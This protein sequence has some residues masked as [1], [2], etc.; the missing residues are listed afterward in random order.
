LDKL[1]SH[2]YI[3]K[4]PIS[5]YGE[6]ENSSSYFLYKIMAKNKNERLTIES[7]SLIE[8][9]NRYLHPPTSFHSIEYDDAGNIIYDYVWAQIDKKKNLKFCSY[10]KA[11]ILKILNRENSQ[12]ISNNRE[13]LFDIRIQ[14][15]NELFKSLQIN[16]DKYLWDKCL[17]ILTRALT[18]DEM[19]FFLKIDN[20]YKKF[21]MNFGDRYARWFRPSNGG[22]TDLFEVIGHYEKELKIGTYAKTR[23]ALKQ[24]IASEDF[25]RGF[26][27]EDYS[28]YFKYVALGKK[29][30][31]DKALELFSSLQA[32][33][34]GLWKEYRYRVREALE[35]KFH[36]TIRIETTIPAEHANEL[37][38]HLGYFA[39][40]FK[41]HL[42]AFGQAPKAPPFHLTDTPTASENVFR[43]EGQNWRITFQGKTI[44][45]RNTKGLQCIAFLLRHPR[46]QF[47]VLNLVREVDGIP[48][49]SADKGHKKS[50]LAELRAKWKEKERQNEDLKKILAEKWK[51]ADSSLIS[52]EEDDPILDFQAM[53]EIN[54]K[55]NWL[56]EQIEEAMNENDIGKEDYLKAE[57]KAILEHLSQASNISGKSRQFIDEGEKARKRVA[58]AIRRA[59][60]AIEKENTD[61]W[62][63][64]NSYINT[65]YHCSYEPSEDIEW[66]F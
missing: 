6:K 19:S 33:E 30:S 25:D 63:H 8:D 16:N 44:S 11:P 12:K 53:A 13:K 2:L 1:L 24:V 41:R 58:V 50:T 46:K 39:D 34:D 43:D 28:L 56:E 59:L 48:L 15:L 49:K 57:K 4:K 26:V 37:E 35:R 5:Y 14:V 51:S 64:L 22:I 29:E 38:L 7:L 32:Q 42:E 23:E 66:S 36:K 17:H 54:N 3:I 55:L 40:Y 20:L 61:L 10:E 65:G 62:R 31:L 18:S 60:E 27:H 45:M 21:E 52:I 9:I 47:H